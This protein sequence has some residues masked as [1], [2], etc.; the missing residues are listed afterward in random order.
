MLLHKGTLL[1]NVL[2]NVFSLKFLNGLVAIIDYNMC[3]IWKT[4]P[5]S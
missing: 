5:D 1:K 3:N 2:K 4:I